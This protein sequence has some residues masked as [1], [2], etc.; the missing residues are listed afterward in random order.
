MSIFFTKNF[1]TK[2]DIVLK[3]FLYFAHFLQGVKPL[4][5]AL[6]NVVAVELF[7]LLELFVEV[8][9]ANVVV[10]GFVFVE[11]SVEG[12]VLTLLLLFCVVS[13]CSDCVVF[14]VMF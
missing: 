10:V 14:C 13:V 4:A 12:S 9:V 8:N 2:F 1:S 7:V 5:I 11:G 3:Q 6:F